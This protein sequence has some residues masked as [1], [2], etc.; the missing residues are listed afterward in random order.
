MCLV[1]RIPFKTNKRNRNFY[2]VL[3]RSSEGK[4]IT[5]VMEETVILN[6][7]YD[8]IGIHTPDLSIY[9]LGIQLHFGAGWYHLLKN[10][11]S[12][13]LF[14]ESIK[15]S[16]NYYKFRKNYSIVIVKAVVP[17]GSLILFD[18]YDDEVISS[19][20]KYTKIVKTIQ[21]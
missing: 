15:R 8:V 16:S 21:F 11:C 9:Y 19:K 20:V 18:S 13:K 4:L 7:L 6:H 10:R 2:K 1:I 14:A 5:P 3:L 17:E 12:A